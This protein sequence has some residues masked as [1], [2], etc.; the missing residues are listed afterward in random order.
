VTAA[1]E[2]AAPARRRSLLFWLGLL[3]AI[4]VL[5]LLTGTPG[6]GA[7]LS[8]RS[9]RP[10]GTRGL[11]LFLGELGAEVVVT[12][13]PPTADDDVALVLADDLGGERRREVRDWVRLGG[14]VVV[15]DSGSPLAGP[16]D[17][18]A[19][20]AGGFIPFFERGECDIAALDAATTVR[21]DGTFDF[22]VDSALFD[23]PEAAESC[24]GDGD[25]ALV[26]ASDEGEG[27]VVS[28]GDPEL[29]TNVNLAE[30]DNAVLAAGLLAPRPG[31][32][33]VVLEA[34]FQERDTTFFDLVPVNVRRALAQLGVAFVLYALWR[35]RRLGR[36][37]VEGQPVEVAG[38]ELVA[39]VGGLL[40]RKA[41][42][43]RSAAVLRAD[44]RR[45]LG[46]HFGIPPHAPPDLAARI[47]ADRTGADPNRLLAALAGAPV[48][49]DA[50][51]TELARLIE[52]VRR[53]VIHGRRGA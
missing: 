21:A 32:R 1:T 42:A 25:A 52:S 43:E 24:F 10:E 17:E 4:V 44:L 14:V 11:V 33:V 13:D 18:G 15:A 40:E 39:A 12:R 29:F 45:D 51:L 23:V 35:A 53:E 28:V 50:E 22:N 19:T 37:V 5:V 34:P 38:S 7:P 3:G 9:T 31:L 41:A 46:V 2:A 47:V 8:P 26:V 36:P 16:I 49:D 20:E 30:E 27:T 6:P 48:G